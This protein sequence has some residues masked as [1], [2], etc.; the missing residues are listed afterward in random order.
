MLDHGPHILVVDDDT[1]LRSLLRRYLVES[2]FLVDVAA[3]ASEARSRLAGLEYDLI[4]MDVMMPGEDGL[5]LTRSLRETLA[6]PILVLTARG[7]PQDRIVGLESGADD[8]LPKP[9]EPRELVLRINSILRRT[10]RPAMPVRPVQMGGAVF[11]PG[12]EELTR[13]GE[14]VRLTAAEL[15]LMKAFAARP[16]ETLTR[17]A[18]VETGAGAAGAPAGGTSPRTVDVQITRLRRKIEPDPRMPRYLLTVRGEGYM[19]RPDPA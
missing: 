9:F 12:R 11:D 2:G 7:R 14:R 15:G 17:E 1:R 10:A 3:D 13:D 8:Y 5:S 6:T 18:L 4:I 16:G 19:L